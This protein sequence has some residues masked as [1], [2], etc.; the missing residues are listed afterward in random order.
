[1]FLLRLII[2]VFISLSISACAIN[3]KGNTYLVETTGLYTLDSG[4]VVRVSVYGDRELTGTFQV[5]DGGAISYPLV[6]QLAVRGLTTKQVAAKISSALANGYMRNPNVAVEMATYRPFF[7]QGE[8]ARSGQYPYVYGMSVRAAIS[9]A[10]GFND[11]AERSF[12]I[13]YRKQGS[14]MIKGTVQ[15]DFPIQPGDTIVITD[16]WL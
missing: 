7:I 13:I 16:R 6:G 15:L 1:M 4:D 2:I 5:G 9:L 12:V 10:G 8:V 3:P 11:T 14:E